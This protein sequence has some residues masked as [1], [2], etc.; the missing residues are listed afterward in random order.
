MLWQE[1][2][3]IP[4]PQKISRNLKGSFGTFAGHEIREFKSVLLR[5]Q[6]R[7]RA[8]QLLRVKQNTKFKSVPGGI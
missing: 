3:V 5:S 6:G 4:C 8:L 2:S 1:R 7:Q